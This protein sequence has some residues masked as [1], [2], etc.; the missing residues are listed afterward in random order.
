MR[1][2]ALEDGPTI[3]V[4]DG[5]SDDQQYRR[6]FGEPDAARIAAARALVAADPSLPDEPKPASTAGGA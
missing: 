5:D 2:V 1:A 4:F 3:L 6:F